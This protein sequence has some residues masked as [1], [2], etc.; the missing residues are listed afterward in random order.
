M[1]RSSGPKK[2]VAHTLE[3][4]QQWIL[5]LCTSPAAWPLGRDTWD[6]F[7]P[8][9]GHPRGFVRVR[10]AVNSAGH[11][12]PWCAHA[13]ILFLIC[14]S[15]LV[16]EGANRKVLLDLLQTVG[17]ERCHPP[18]NPDSPGLAPSAASFLEGQPSPRSNLNSLGK[19]F[20]GPLLLFSLL[21]SQCCLRPLLQMGRALGTVEALTAC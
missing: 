16:T 7:C 18:P 21:A 17:T 11:I 3:A 1:G 5:L 4:A 14:N 13:L 15:P 12:P 19:A 8:S 2:C 6:V 10:P 20:P 9:P